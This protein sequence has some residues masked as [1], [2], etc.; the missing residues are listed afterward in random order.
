MQCHWCGTQLPTGAEFSREVFHCPGCGRIVPS[1]NSGYAISPDEGTVR[2]FSNAPMQ[3][4]PP[5][6]YG[7]SSYEERNPYTYNPYEQSAYGTDIPPQSPL[8]YQNALPERGFSQFIKTHMK[9]VILTAVLLFWISLPVLATKPSDT[10]NSLIDNLCVLL[11]LIFW[12]T[13]LVLALYQTARLKRWGWFVCI[14]L[15]SPIISVGSFIY[16][17]IGPTTFRQYPKSA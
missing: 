1:Q 11:L 7:P 13:S 16:V 15:L 14:L 17:L 8:P 5:T 3:P 4:S 6:N 10:P 12:P 2:S 9:L